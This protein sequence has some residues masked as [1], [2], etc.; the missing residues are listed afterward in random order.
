LRPEC[1]SSVR[2]RSWLA[3]AALALFLTSCSG[4]PADSSPMDK[5][6]TANTG[7]F[8][9]TSP[10]FADGAAIPKQFTCEGANTSPELAWGG[11]PADTESF[12]LIM[13]DP[14]APSGTF[15]HWVIFDIPKTFHGLKAG[16]KAGIPSASTSRE[17][18]VEGMNDFKAT[19]ASTLAAIGYGGPCP[20]PG[21]PHHYVFRLY[22]LS[23]ELGLGQ[24]VLRKGVEDAMNGKILAQATLT[25]TFA[26]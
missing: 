7:A 2:S 8:T 11:A 26:R 20:P 3:L 22:A 15:T 16:L 18:G 14:D 4:S 6:K 21:K 25:G 23:Q 13:E 10:D 19:L 17:G 1:P 12:A 24:G 5:T 9:L